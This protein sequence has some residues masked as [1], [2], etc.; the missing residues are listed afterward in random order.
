[1]A[2]KRCSYS[3]EGKLLIICWIPSDLR[4]ELDRVWAAKALWPHGR[5]QQQ[6]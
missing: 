4:M 5:T 2:A 6:P 3:S 1:M